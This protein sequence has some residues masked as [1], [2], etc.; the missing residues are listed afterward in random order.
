MA[1]LGRDANG[2][3]QPSASATADVVYVLALIGED[4]AGAA[5]T[6]GGQSALDALAK[7]APS[8]VY[9]DAGRAGRV[10]RAVALAGGDPHSFGGLNLIATINAAYDPATGRYHP[11]LYGHT[12]AVEG[13]LRAGEPVPNAAI[14]A[15][16]QAQLPDGSWHWSFSGTQGDVDTTGRV[17]QVLG[18]EAHMGC[19]SGYAHAADYLAA[20]QTSNG[21][22][23]FYY[24]L[25]TGLDPKN[26]L[27]NADSTGLAVAGLR[28]AGYDPQ[29]V[30]FQKN[31]R[32]AVDTLLTYQEAS[33]AFAY[34]QPS[35]DAGNLL[36]TVDALN[37]LAQPLVAQPTCRSLY[38]PLVIR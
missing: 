17:M 24:P 16:I 2:N 12:L 23:S 1:A 10:A 22:W 34:V 35:S 32:G 6:V 38:L 31:G 30:P 20:A 36:T 29:A 4:P 21:D 11:I 5:W 13:L 9:A 27:P 14:N 37:G 7:L 3:C 18:G 15:L 26:N 25:P 28:G 33:G 8:Y 19:F